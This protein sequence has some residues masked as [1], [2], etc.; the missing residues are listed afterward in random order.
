MSKTEVKVSDGGVLSA[1]LSIENVGEANYT[2]K[3][4][5][6]RDGD[7]EIRREGWVLF[8]P[9]T[10]GANT[11]AD[12]DLTER[13]IRLAELLRPNG[14]RVVVGGSRTKIRKFDTVSQLWSDI[15]IGF[16]P[17]RRWQTQT[18]NGYMILNNTVNLPVTYRVEEAS[19]VPIYE[20]REIGIASVDRIVENNGFLLLVGVVEIQADQLNHWMAGYAN[21]TIGPTVAKSADFTILD[22]DSGTEFDIT[23]SG[24]PVVVTLPTAPSD[25]FYVWIKKTAGVD[26]ITTIPAITNQVI[27]ITA[28]GDTALI[29]WDPVLNRYAAKRFAGGVIPAF[30]P[31]GVVPADITNHIPWEVVNGEFGKPRNWAPKF[32]I[33]LNAA[34]TVLTLPFASTLFQKG[35]LVGVDKAGL[36]GGMLGGDENN[37]DGILVTNVVGNQVT[38]AI[39]TDTAIT[40]PRT[41]TLMRWTDV[42]T[43]VVKYLL[44]GDG[45]PVFAAEN[46][47]NLLILYRSTGA[48]VGRY[49]GIILDGQGN[50]TGP[51]TFRPVYPKGF[52]VPRWADAIISVNGDYHLY[53]SGKHFYQYD[54]S[55]NPPEIHKETD[56]VRNLFFDNLIREDDEVWAVDNPKTNEAWFI[57]PGV[58]TLAFD[59]L[60]RT[61]SIIDVG[62]DAAAYIQRPGNWLDRWFIVGIDRLVST[63]AFVDGQE[64]IRSWLRN[65]VATGWQIATGLTSLKDQGNEKDLSS[66]TPILASSSPDYKILVEMFATHNPSAVVR[67]L[68]SKQLP[69]P[70]GQNYLPLYFRAIYFM[71]RL[72]GVDTRDIDFRMSCQLW[73]FDK[74][75][76]GGINRSF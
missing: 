24:T 47:Q 18:I 35:S 55:T 40:Y 26:L 3:V 48:Y 56:V 70:R 33:K 6:R 36:D 64:A 58:L 29:W 57:R 41:V 76:A 45:S 62:F 49:T 72:S 23:T 51:F 66:Y 1:S 16:S 19:V 43:L 4:N 31:Y 10:A 7:Q 8:K 73:E 54:G 38:L 68:F 67:Q 59:Y 61:C 22:G 52:N 2:A 11:Q 69:T 34:T 63:Y 60:K 14:D 21:Y 30:D 12:Y 25:S 46:L 44:Q 17:G 53:P 74:I 5:L 13:V 15:G 28:V 75:N 37:P 27:S 39:T 65:G 32:T 20:L 50:Q 42:N 71:V 9:T